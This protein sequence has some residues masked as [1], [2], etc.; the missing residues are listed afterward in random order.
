M[1]EILVLPLVCALFLLLL[2]INN[3]NDVSINVIFTDLE[4]C[5]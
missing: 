4:K 3:N 1:S 5:H 2:S